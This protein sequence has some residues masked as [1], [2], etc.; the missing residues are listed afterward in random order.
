M[1]AIKTTHKGMDIQGFPFLD[2]PLDNNV[3]Q[4]ILYLLKL[5][6]LC[7]PAQEGEPANYS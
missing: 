3:K 1:Y 2:A 6:A 7:D 5:K 4:S